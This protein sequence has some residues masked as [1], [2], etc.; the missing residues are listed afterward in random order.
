MCLPQELVVPVHLSEEDRAAGRYEGLCKD[1][2]TE[3]RGEAPKLVAM[4]LK[5]V[6]GK[7][8]FRPGAYMS[9]LSQKCVRC[10]LKSNDGLLYPLDKSF[11]FIHKPTTYIRY[12]EV[13]SV[14]F[15]R[16]DISGASAARTFDVAVH[17]KAL[18][19][20]PAR[21]YTFQGIDRAEK[22]VLK[23]FLEGR[24]L[25]VIEALPAKGAGAGKIDFAEL[26]DDEDDEG[27]SDDGRCSPGAQRAHT[28]SSARNISMIIFIEPAYTSFKYFPC[29]LTLLQTRTTRTTTRQQLRRGAR[30]G[31]GATTTTMTTRRTTT[32]TAGAAATTM[33]TTTMTAEMTTM[34]RALRVLLRFELLL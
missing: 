11:L 30:G 6:T 2:S 18:G 22:D 17:C 7:P 15:Q 21:S 12:G 34:V 13:D 28:L 24:Q 16:S 9:T 25:R 5:H 10:S 32:I 20:E 23:S 26:D 19:S 1:G 3:L 8:V 4:L 14:E 29:Y 33:M 27:G 31:E